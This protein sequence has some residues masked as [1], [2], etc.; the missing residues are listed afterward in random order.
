[1]NHTKTG[2]DPSGEAGA[3]DTGE[4]LREA[5]TEAAY[6]FPLPPLPLTAIERDGH[7]RRLRRR[8]AVLGTGCGLLLVPLAVFGLRTGDSPARPSERVI[9]PAATSS[10]SPSPSPSSSSVPA[11]KVRVVESGERVTAGS[12]AEI[13]L[14]EEGKYWQLPHERDM[15]PQ[16]RS[17][18]DGNLD[19]T[20]PNV[21]L[22]EEGSGDGD[23]F[24][25]G[26]YVGKGEAARVAIELA[27]GTTLGGTVLRLA[28]TAN[29][30]VWYTDA[31]PPDVPANDTGFRT[32]TKKV[33]VYDAGDGVI[34]EMDFSAP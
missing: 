34:A 20:E 12:G 4:R 19:M 15:E 18:V 26:V 6:T 21:S 10:A 23:L 30:G 31:T 17:V 22:Q 25:S 2:A 7:R 3:D 5:L 1:M 32:A 8:A 29:W 28:D 9:P 24:L 13:W 16:F 11:G 14:T 33:T 27:D